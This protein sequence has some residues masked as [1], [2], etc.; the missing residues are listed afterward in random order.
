[1]FSNA[2][3]ANHPRTLVVTA[4]AI[5]VI[6]L[7]SPISAAEFFAGK[8]IDLLIGAPPAGGYDIY[9]R[10]LGRHIGRH[11]PGNPTIVAKNMP[12]AGSARVG[13]F[14]S[15]VAPKDGTAIAALMPGAIIG[16][17]LDPRGE[18][19][20]DP[21]K[22]IYV[23][24]ANNGTRVCVSR[25]DSKV[26]T[27]DDALTEKAPFGAVSANDSTR[28]YAWLHKRTAGAQYNV[29]LGYAGTADIA[30]A[31]ER[32]EIDGACG[33]DWSSFKSQRPDWL[34]DKKVNVLLQVGREPNEE[35]T[36]MGVP[37]VWKYVKTDE[38]R[39]IVE[40]VIGQ[41]VFQRPYV[42]PPGT[43][44]EQ[45]ATLRKAF[46]ATM[47]DPQFLEEAAKLRI[48]ITPL[49]GSKV[50]EVVQTLYATPKDVVEQA[51]R[52]INP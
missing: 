5:L 25:R 20:F 38:A 30:L 21:T 10:S 32:G 12:G 49:P 46:D 8:S 34:R 37:S 14:I 35:L 44:G 1:M 28:D 31:M 52:A 47:A 6:G 23:G 48:D 41:Q 22:V 50:Q 2:A 17:L 4:A 43:P 29:V 51:R 45:V 27:F 19:L 13:G 9:G 33:W 40:L 24:T 11:I 39:K 3:T 36:R 18:A 7:A 16:Q 42:V 26:K 15:A